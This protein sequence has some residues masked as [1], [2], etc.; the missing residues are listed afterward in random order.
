VPLAVL[1]L[2]ETVR[3]EVLEAGS[4]VNEALVQGGSPLTLS[5]TAPPKPF[6]GVIVTA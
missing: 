2:V 5:C 6:T 1:G 4:G 3:V